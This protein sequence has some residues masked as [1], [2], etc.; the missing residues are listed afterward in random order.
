MET[1][2]P[3]SIANRKTNRTDSKPTRQPPQTGK[4]QRQTVSTTEPSDSSDHDSDRS[5]LS[6]VPRVKERMGW[7]VS[8]DI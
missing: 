7:D 3:M 1:L 8:S 4:K 2:E 6:R 5:V